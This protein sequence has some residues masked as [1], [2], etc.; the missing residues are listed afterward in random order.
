M[1]EETPAPE[2]QTRWGRQPMQQPTTPAELTPANETQQRMPK[3][4]QGTPLVGEFVVP[5]STD[6]SKLAY[7]T[8]ID[9]NIYYGYRWLR[10]TEGDNSKDYFSTEAVLRLGTS[11]NKVFTAGEAAIKYPFLM[12][13][14][15]CRKDN[16][17]KPND[18]FQRAF[19]RE[20]AEQI[21]AKALVGIKSAPEY[22][23]AVAEI[24][25]MVPAWSKAFQLAASTKF[26]YDD[27]SEKHERALRKVEVTKRDKDAVKKV[28]DAAKDEQTRVEL[29]LGRCWS[30]IKGVAKGHW[31]EW[32]TSEAQK[33]IKGITN[34]DVVHQLELYEQYLPLDPVLRGKLIEFGVK[35][36]KKTMETL[37]EV[38]AEE[39]AKQPETPAHEAA[40]NTEGTG[41]EIPL[42][43]VACPV[44]MPLISE[45]VAA[46]MAQAVKSRTKA[47]VSAAASKSGAQG[48]AGNKA[49]AKDEVKVEA[50][51]EP[52]RTVLPKEP[53][54]DSRM[55]TAY[56]AVALQIKM[57]P[58][59]KRHDWCEELCS[60]LFGSGLGETAA[61]NLLPFEDT[62]YV[63]FDQISKE[64]TGKKPADT[65]TM[66]NMPQEGA[67]S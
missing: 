34:E 11:G 6:G 54:S 51:V 13:P 35:P 67:A 66:E 25:K 10:L 7:V 50:G 57:L 9:N 37:A 24:E 28:L 42:P 53:T 52:N 48:G 55:L 23:A 58:K 14:L 46:K 63:P 27:A 62:K 3:G 33:V 17:D 5:S 45:A 32:I 1:A 39:K 49:S 47:K 41:I 20:L 2:T 19:T 15:Q 40:T 21:F 8:R 22:I 31:T 36:T 43:V 29:S 59:E 12:E 60:L 4:R 44:V 65:E 64:P 56:D 16:P 30:A 26:D 38:V 18:E 61:V